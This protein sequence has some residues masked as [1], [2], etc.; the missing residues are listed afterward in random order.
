ML[1]LKNIY[2]TYS[3]KNG[4]THRA[5]ENVSLKFDE[6]G[7]VFILGKSGSGKSTLLNLLGGIDSYDRG[8]ISFYDKK[9]SSFKENDFDYYRNS[10]VGFIFQDFNLLDNLTV[11][12][13][14]RLAL[15]L[16]SKKDHDKIIELLDKVS[17]SHLKNRKISELSG[18]QKQRVAIARALVKEPKIILADEPTGALD[19]DTSTDI[20]KIL[21]SLAKDRL[22]VVV[23]HNKEL[24]YEYAERIIEIRDGFVLKDLIR[25]TLDENKEE[26]STLVSSNLVIVP[27]GKQLSL[28]NIE[29]LNVT[30]SEKRQDYYLLVENDKHRAMSLFP[31]V[32]EVINDEKN[33]DLFKPYRKNKDNKTFDLKT[34]KTSFPFLK[35]MKFS[36]SSMKKRKLKLFFTIIISVLSVILTGSAVNFTNYTL[37]N[38]VGVSIEKDSGTQLEVSSSFS[39]SEPTYKLQNSEIQY[40]NSL[41]KETGYLFDLEMNY[42]YSTITNN[43]VDNN[44]KKDNLLLDEKLSGFLM[45]DDIS[46]FGYDSNH[47]KVIHEMENITEEDRK[48]GV[49][50]SSILANTIVRY[51]VYDTTNQ[52]DFN[53]I[54][55]IVG[56]TI[57]I[58]CPYKTNNT[59]FTVL[60]IFDVDEKQTL[61][62]KF[63]GLHDNVYDQ[64][65]YD[66][67]LA[68]ADSVLKRLVVSEEFI[69]YF[70]ESI[71][72]LDI[73]AITKNLH[74]NDT[75]ANRVVSASSID[76]EVKN[77]QIDFFN[78]EWNEANFN[79][80][81]KTMKKNEV[82]INRDLFKELMKTDYRD[83][84]MGL[85]QN[86]IDTFNNTKQDLVI[87]NI[88]SNV[89]LPIETYQAIEDIKIIGV[90]IRHPGIN[91]DRFYVSNDC[92]KDL[93][94]NYYRA[95]KALIKMDKNED[96]AHVVQQLYDNGFTINDDFVEDFLKFA[97]T[98]EKFSTL[99]NIGVCVWFVIVSMLLYS[100]MSNSIKDSSKQ[101]GILKAL[102][103]T[104]SDIYKVFAVE[105]AFIGLFS[106]V[107]G[108]LGYYLVGILVNGIVTSLF[109]DFYFTIFTFD[110][111]SVIVM[112]ISIIAILTVSLIIPMSKIRNIKPIDVINANN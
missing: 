104:M 43:E 85:M 60:G 3:S 6:K 81:V 50:I 25:S 46:N 38:A 21:Q 110:I 74:N 48:T 54:E 44:I 105:A 32:S 107:L 45:C 59:K 102:G 12:E 97:S 90:V 53:K 1:E 100:F 78:S 11:Y 72:Y 10:C 41:N 98:I 65:L 109:Y 99:I 82:I 30:I 42:K 18:G 89:N 29:D 55:N 14:V 64:K 5:L 26:Q 4:V 57:M 52:T 16:Q 34:K 106:I 95:S 80:K 79:E 84:R 94:D 77:M 49:Y 58:D 61:Y 23:T 36:F 91:S 13:N 24:A 19:S 40:L 7:L 68:N 101:I 39:L 69:E 103:S 35:C 88:R 67:Y 62:N 83:S 20:F 28:E 8:E 93:L 2:K 31:N 87:E 33:E 9:F 76:M 111:I 73:K 63:K 70:K 51:N 92:Y 17:V 66:S 112:V 71:R 37:S 22:V 15:D 27:K 108:V 75:V 47:Y 56:D 96:Y 86:Y